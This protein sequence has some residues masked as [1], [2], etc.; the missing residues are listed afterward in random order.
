MKKPFEIVKLRMNVSV[1]EILIQGQ[2]PLFI[3]LCEQVDDLEK[4]IREKSDFEAISQ[5][6]I[7]VEICS[8]D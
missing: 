8:F 4:Q 2:Y 1:E 3:G 6:K 5:E 7:L